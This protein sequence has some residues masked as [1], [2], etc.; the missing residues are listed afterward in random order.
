MP[1]TKTN[2]SSQSKAPA[3]F[4]QLAIPHDNRPWKNVGFYSLRSNR[5]AEAEERIG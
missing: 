1:H 3:H 2:R 4:S 5:C